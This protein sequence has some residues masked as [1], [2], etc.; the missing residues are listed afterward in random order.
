LTSLAAGCPEAR[1]AEEANAV[2]NSI[3][4]IAYFIEYV[5]ISFVRTTQTGRYR[6]LS[7]VE[8]RKSLLDV[9]LLGVS[10]I[11]MI[12]PLVY[13]FSSWLDFANYQLPTWTGWLGAILFAGAIW[14]LWRSH[15]D[16]G[17]NWTPVLGIRENHKLVT[18]GVFKYIRHPMYA[19]HLLWGIASVLMLHNWIA[20]YSL[21]VVF[22]AQFLSRI[23]AEEQMMLDQFGEEYEDYMKET[24]RILPR[25]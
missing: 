19:A 9:I 13:V 10:G 1:D 5:V 21:I 4:K 16:L 3:L 14:L 17:R 24:G 23:R 22:S 15:V 12:I 18:E 11:G 7:V 2:F 6:Q 8:D 25:F 20:G